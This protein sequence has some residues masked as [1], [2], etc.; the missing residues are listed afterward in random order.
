M[1]W[2]H[3]PSI[4]NALQYI[5]RY[6]SAWN[7]RALDLRNQTFHRSIIDDPFLMDTKM[8]QSSDA[9]NDYCEL[10]NSIQRHTKCIAQSCLRRKGTTLLC[11]Y[12]APWIIQEKSTLSNVENGQPKHTPARNDD[13][14]N[15]HNPFILSIWRANVDCQPVLSIDAVIK[16]IAKY[17]AKA[18]NKSETYHQMLSRISTNFEPDKPT[19][20][21]F[22]KMLVENLVDR[23]I[24]AQETCHLLL[25]LPLSLSSRTFVSLNVNQKNF[26]R[27]SISPTRT[28]TYPNYMATYMERPI[29]LERMCLIDVTKKWSFNA[30]QKRNQ[31][32]ERTNPVIVRVSPRFTSIPSKEDK[33]FQAFCWSE[34]LLYHPFR[35]IEMDFG[36]SDDEIKAQWERFS[37]NYH[38]WHVHRTTSTTTEESDTSTPASEP[39]QIQQDFLTEWK[40]LS[41]L[42]PGIPI[43]LDELDMLG[44]PE[45][46]LSH[47]WGKHH[48]PTQQKVVAT[49]FIHSNQTTFQSHHVYNQ[50]ATYA[51]SIQQQRAYDLVITHLQ[52]NTLKP[53]LK[54]IVQ[55]TAGTGK[56]HLITSIKSTMMRLAPPGQSP[57]LLLA[58][59][60]VA[61]FNI[62][63]STIH[64]ALRIPIKEMVPLQ[65]QTLASFQESMYFIHYILI[66]EMSFIGR[67]LIQCIDMRLHEAFPTHNQIPFGGRSIILFGDLG[68]LPPVKDIPMYASN[69]YGG[70][71]W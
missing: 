69:S 34:L 12:K 36:S 63:A 29:H 11:R 67:R 64:S 37:N 52:H 71:L 51:L 41:A 31:W 53:P 25:K 6:V 2:N 65:G 32:K 3:I 30:S 21:A 24:G 1:Q 27:V 23:D 39:E 38:P 50:Q 58:P 43:Q 28:T 35:N 14:L 44:Q 46:D 20:N 54:I 66:D 59:T 16:Y 7:P 9:S 62:Q 22:Q 47:D 8:I 56:S 55:G 57:L 10:V 18:E 26:Q 4:Q 15:L 68:Q 49:T 70:T 13:R 48:I 19:P 5:D 33:Y 42:Y 45:I 17:A 40:A 61:A 60:G